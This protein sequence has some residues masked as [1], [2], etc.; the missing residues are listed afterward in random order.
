MVYSKICAFNVSFISSE[1]GTKFYSNFSYFSSYV[2]S[3]HLF[4]K[5][6]P[7]LRTIDYTN[8]V[9]EYKCN[10]L[11]DEI[12]LCLLYGVITRKECKSSSK[13]AVILRSFSTVSLSEKFYDSMRNISFKNYTLYA[14]EILND[15]PLSF[16]WNIKLT[17]WD[18]I[19]TS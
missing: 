7:Q 18:N 14:I 16:G 11:A 6:F 8:N 15:S 12:A 2:W 17:F 5:Y 10:C 13:G 4:S 1:T 3:K 9:P 19:I